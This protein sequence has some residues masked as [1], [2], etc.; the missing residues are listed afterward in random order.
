MY[1][2]FVSLLMALMVLMPSLSVSAARLTIPLSG[3]G[4][5]LWRDADASWQDDKLYLP[6]EAIDLSV[7]PVNPPTGGWDVLKGN[8]PDGTFSVKVPGTDMEYIE[9][10]NNQ[11]ESRPDHVKGVC[12][13]WREIEIPADQAGK[14]ILIDFEGVRLRAE[15]Y[16]DGRLVAYDII[17]ETPFSADITDA[18]RAGSKQ[19][20]A[21]RI[22]N[23]GGN[24]SWG[25]FT[26]EKWGNTNQMMPQ[27]HGFGGITGRV[28]IHCVD[29]SADIADI[30]VKNKA[31]EDFKSVDAVVTLGNT[32]GA[33][34]AR[35][36]VSD[37]KNPSTVHFTRTIPSSSFSD[38]AFEVKDI[39]FNGARLWDID[40]PNL[41][42]VNVELLDAAGNV[43]DNDSRHFGFRWFEAKGFGSDCN[44]YLNG[45]RIVLRSAISWGYWSKGGLY[46][47]K[48]QTIEQANV[49]KSLGLNCLNFHRNIGGPLMLETADE[50]GLLYFEEP[51][52]YH[53][54]VEDFT[55]SILFEKVSRMIYRDRTH[56]SLVIYN[57]INE[58]F[59]EL[60]HN[61][62]LI[63]KR[64]ADM[65]EFHKIDNTRFLT[66][67]SGNTPGV[68]SQN[69]EELHK[70]H[71]RPYD[72]T[73]Y[74]I[75]WQDVHQAGAPE[76]WKEGMYRGPDNLNGVA[77][78]NPKDDVID[79]EIWV[80]G[81]E[82][83][84]STPPRIELIHNAIQESGELGWDGLFWENQ[85]DR[86]ARFFKEQ[87][88]YKYYG[89]IDN[90]TRIMGDVS[91]DHQ[92]RRITNFRM[93][94]AGDMYTI[95]G[96]ESE[97]YDNH[98]GVVDIYRNPKGNPEILK[99]ANAPL[100]LAVK[101]RNQIVKSPATAVVD[102]YL[103]NEQVLPAGTYTLKS[104]LVAPSG[105]TLFS[106]PDR[107]VTIKAG[108]TYGQ[109]LADGVEFNIPEG[110]EGT[111][112]V[113]AELVGGE[114]SATGHDEIL[115]VD[116]S[117]DDFKG[118]G[119]YYGSDSSVPTFYKNLTGK[120][121]PSY[122]SS[123]GKLDWIIVNRSSFAE[124]VVITANDF[125]DLSRTWYGDANFTSKVRTEKA[126]TVDFYCNNGAQPTDGVL[127][128]GPYSILYEGKINVPATGKYEFAVNTLRGQEIYLRDADGR[129]LWHA[130]NLGNS[131]NNSYT[132]ELN[133]EEGQVLSLELKYKHD[134][135]TKDGKIQ[136]VWARPDVVEIDPAEILDRAMT[137]GT[138]VIIIGKAEKWL[139]KIAEVTDA[140]YDGNYTVGKDWVGGIHF[141][142]DHPVM[143]GLPVN[144]SFGWQYQ[145]LV[146]DGNNR[147]GFY[148]QGSKLIVGSTR[149]YSFHLG[150]SM[151]E[152]EYGN[153]HIIFS[154]LKIA[155]NLIAA[156]GP[157]EVA[158]K[159][160][161]NLTNYSPADYFEGWSPETGK[162]PYRD[163]V[164]PGVVEAEDFDLGGEGVSYHY[165]NGESQRQE[166]YEKGKPDGKG[167]DYVY[168]TEWVKINEALGVIQNL[169]GGDW[170]EYTVNV[171]EDGDYEL[172]S[173]LS[174]G[175]NGNFQL[176][177]DG[178]KVLA[179]QEFR[180]P[181]EIDNK[182]NYYFP[183]VSKPIQL[184]KGTHVFR[185]GDINGL[186]MDK[187][188]FTRI[189]DLGTSEFFECEVPGQVEAENYIAGEDNYSFTNGTSGSY[190]QYRIDQGVAISKDG[191][192]NGEHAVFVSNMSP[193]D[194]LSYDV[195]CTA[196]GNYDILA[197][198]ATIGRTRVILNID[199]VDYGSDSDPLVIMRDELEN[200]KYYGGATGDFHRFGSKKIASAF[201]SEGK[202][203][204]KI[205][206]KEASCNFDGLYFDIEPQHF[207]NRVPGKIEAENYDEGFG[208]YLW[209]NGTNNGNFKSY[210]RHKGVAISRSQNG[211]G[212]ASAPGYADGEYIVHL[213]ST[214]NGNYVTYT[215]ECDKE[216]DYVAYTCV[217]TI[218]NHKCY[219][220]IDGEDY[221]SA[222]DPFVFNTNLGEWQQYQEF[223]LPD[224]LFHLS[225]GTHEIVY[226]MVAAS[227]NMDYL[228]L[229]PKEAVGIDEFHDDYEGDGLWYT[230]DGVP[231]ANPVRNAFNI[232]NGRKIFVK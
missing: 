112:Q 110:G 203:I 107:S 226:H 138:S 75:G 26:P 198:I 136:L 82:G 231:H 221:G 22:T 197:R 178:E 147:Q 191:D 46:S 84:L 146:D 53:S 183:V 176:Y 144:T 50:M 38:G 12:W 67:C 14:R 69:V 55:R 134:D 215:F 97:P 205:Y 123:M 196:A 166:A 120:E 210:R 117:A 16:V 13:W 23:P 34:S 135:G 2:F 124:P 57:L 141:N 111:Y 145:A 59:G 218:G 180:A 27:T 103:I 172:Q 66:L 52:S 21:V 116:Y 175:G 56:P 168:R 195:N 61:Q 206:F 96:W 177:I 202:H 216:A 18:I 157:A 171:L 90:L 20:L 187:F 212:N 33:A 32:S 190:K 122:T 125:S 102:F 154:D 164:L 31:S 15:V 49:A 19:T 35:L 91:F 30:W 76:T 114:V 188:V 200:V 209:P 98:S 194:W 224:V 9:P 63:N 193:G 81:E 47:T 6:S 163:H 58:F 153:G 48:E 140:R 99:E 159:L 192:I 142:I 173:Y 24:T 109:L 151:G 162:R 43:L 89:S 149:T 41:Y 137:D 68:N 86:Y 36:T 87:D 7:L 10:A 211:V 150:T 54:G 29:S 8:G 104:S 184:K 143:K 230:I 88:L 78:Y 156:D 174:T 155:D 73:L 152:I 11:R 5:K 115:A 227:C 186:N 71:M 213:A 80:R 70:S 201:L 225:E 100:L 74:Q 148:L 182:W 60:L 121:L 42:Q 51:G 127:A 39:T 219:I 17:A 126:S 45:R 119:A 223:M 130:Q 179:K 232:H 101:T 77:S 217:A 129:E 128:N 170:F 108:D 167:R 229:I 214:S 131:S 132:K 220:T 44:F 204:V 83:A 85:Y 169:S 64:L 1:R 65:K 94:N 79:K 118:E 139:G 72:D 4:W 228:M 25:D 165:K 28:N 158:K 93:R 199:G 92:A 37:Y 95:N 3:G 113:V 222:S 40:T 133:L 160:L 189:G 207:D 106:M 181:E 185:F 161:V 62:P 208:K 105:A